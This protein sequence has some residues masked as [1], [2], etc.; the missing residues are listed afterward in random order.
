M[1]WTFLHFEEKTPGVMDFGG[2]SMTFPVDL[3]S[4]AKKDTPTG[5]K[6]GRR[7]EG[8]QPD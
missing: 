3:R 1:A 5:D 2:T 6:R 4:L 8:W 7:L